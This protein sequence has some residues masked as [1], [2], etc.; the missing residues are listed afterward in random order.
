LNF[1]RGSHYEA[2]VAVTTYY[3]PEDIKITIPQDSSPAVEVCV[4]KD[5]KVNDIVI[6]AK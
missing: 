5:T 2:V 3:R 4:P 1:P 6:W